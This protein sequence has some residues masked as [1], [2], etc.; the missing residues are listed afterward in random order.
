MCFGVE[1]IVQI[2]RMWT[3]LCRLKI[4]IRYLYDSV[5]SY[6][7][8]AK[9]ADGLRVEETMCYVRN[10]VASEWLKRAFIGK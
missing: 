6:T 2:N 10:I 1:I 8:L 3:E 9:V 7:L 5:V 4:S